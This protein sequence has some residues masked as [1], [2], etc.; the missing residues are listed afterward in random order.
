MYTI[1]NFSVGLGI[2]NNISLAHN[3]QLPLTLI[4]ISININRKNC[5]TKVVL[6]PTVSLESPQVSDTG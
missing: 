4:H 6:I 2:C 3:A 5:N 1:Q